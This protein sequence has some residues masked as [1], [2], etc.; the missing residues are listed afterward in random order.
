MDAPPAELPEEVAPEVRS[1]SEYVHERCDITRVEVL[2]AGLPVVPPTGA[3]LRWTGN[4]CLPNPTL[5][6]QAL[7][8]GA[9]VGSWTARPRLDLWVPASVAPRDVGVGEAFEPVPGEAP[10][11]A[12]QAGTLV[13]R[14]QSRIP[15]SAG[16]PVTPR[17]A[18]KLPDAANGA[19]VD[20]IVQIGQ[21]RVSAPGKLVGAGTIGRPVHVR[22]AVSGKVHR[23]VL[24]T[25]NTVHVS[26]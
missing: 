25:A 23:G 15:I 17:V 13:G 19:A 14:V 1:L 8:D 26:P 7:A 9:L 4:P 6:L 11:R 22:N 12:A 20:I 16:S 3:R 21:V 2:T 10:W 5:R 18:S 24:H